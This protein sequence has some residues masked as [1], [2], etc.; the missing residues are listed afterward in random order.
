MNDSSVILI[1]QLLVAGGS[2]ELAKIYRPGQQ[3]INHPLQIF[4]SME[5][6]VTDTDNLPKAFI[7]NVSFNALP[8]NV[9]MQTLQTLSS[10]KILLRLQHIFEV[11]ED[12][13]LS[14][15]ATVD[16]SVMFSRNITGLVEVSLTGNQ[17]ISEM[18]QRRL[19][20]RI[21]G[22]P[23]DIVNIHEGKNITNPYLVTLRPMQTRTFLFNGFSNETAKEKFVHN[24]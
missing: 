16:L 3:L 18:N 5:T 17:E 9:R 12:P 7:Q 23:A 1:N 13:I 15:L 22:D 6:R 19:K 2:N 8:I 14:K 20:W 21:A 24:T 11:G 10:G 4:F